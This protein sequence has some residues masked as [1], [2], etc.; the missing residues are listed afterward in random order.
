M[1]IIE[2]CLANRLPR[3]AKCL[4]AQIYRQNWSIF[5]FNRPNQGGRFIERQ[6]GLAK[7]CSEAPKSSEP[8]YKFKATEAFIILPGLDWFY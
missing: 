4:E 6:K 1:A 3:S 7:L 2:S 5:V 8:G